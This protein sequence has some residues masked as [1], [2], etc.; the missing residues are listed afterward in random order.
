MKR[1]AITNGHGAWFDIEKTVCYK[2]MTNYNGNN[3][4]SRATNSQWIHEEIL[5]TSGIFILHHWSEAYGSSDSFDVISEQQ[6]AQWFTSQGFN[7]NDIPE[8]LMKEVK[9]LELT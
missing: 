8:I 7:D 6:A 9:D 2:E 3:H 5:I 1:T 4:I